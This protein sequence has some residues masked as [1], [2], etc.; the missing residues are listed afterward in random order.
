MN[1][2]QRETKE[3]ITPVDKHKIVMKTYITGKE[4]K[5]IKKIWQNIEVTIEKDK[6]T[7]KPINVGD[8][9]EEAERKVVELVIISVD[10]ETEN[11]VDLILA[12][13]K[14]DCT[15]IEKEIDKVTKDE[16]EDEEKKNNQ[17]ISE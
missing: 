10:G 17:Q 12:M 1:N 13:R 3:I 4:D 14:K 11:V 9:L 8:R 15:L 2:E 6:Q 7:S 5:E 16:D